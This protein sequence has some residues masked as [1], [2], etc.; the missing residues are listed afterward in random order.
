MSNISYT[1]GQLEHKQ[2]LLDDV[3]RAVLTLQA[4]ALGLRVAMQVDDD[5]V[6][7]SRRIADT[8]AHEVEG[9]LA[10]QSP[11]PIIGALIVRMMALG[12]PDADWIQDLRALRNALVHGRPVP[13]ERLIVLAELV[14]LVDREF[15]EDL[16]RLYGRR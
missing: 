1:S 2:Q 12:K 3:S 9:A 15:T 10:A 5:A 14:R 8:F 11:D 13:A 7:R 16:Y 6:E 4:D